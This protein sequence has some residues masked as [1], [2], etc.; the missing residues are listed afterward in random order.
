LKLAEVLDLPVT[1]W[2][3]RIAA[4]LTGEMEQHL[5]EKISTIPEMRRFLAVKGYRSSDSTLKPASQAS[6]ALT[7]CALR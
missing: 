3:K 2:D 1:S 7:R 4:D 6:A 5:A